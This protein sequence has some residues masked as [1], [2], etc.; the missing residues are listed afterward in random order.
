MHFGHMLAGNCKTASLRFA[1]SG[2]RKVMR[3]PLAVR[4]SYLGRPE[5]V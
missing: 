4:L 5:G 3:E 1:L 2:L